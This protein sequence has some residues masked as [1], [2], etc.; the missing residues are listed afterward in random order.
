MTSPDRLPAGALPPVLGAGALQG[1]TFLDVGCGSGLFSLAA[2]RL[3]AARV[4]SFDCDGESVAATQE[5]KRRFAPD[6]G[7]WQ[8]E[9]GDVLDEGYLRSLGEWD[10]VYAW[11]VLHHTGEMWRAL[12]NAMSR[13]RPGGTIF[14]AIYNDQGALS[15]IWRTIKRGYNRSRPTRWAIIALFV[16]AM[17]LHG[18]V[19]DV[20]RA[21]R[22]PLDRYR[23]YAQRSRGMSPRHDWL[24][25]LGGYP[26]EV[27]RPREVVGF[28]EARGFETKTVRVVDGWGCNQ[29]VFRRAR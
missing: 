19:M 10:V 15:R 28:C 5:V 3:G 1:A 21:R 16:P 4:R 2:A 6:A 20:V 9:Q 17:V 27:A 7:A 11:G 8:I 24:D 12:E 14:I 25:W 22:N 26:Y 13:V 18:A 29:F 23:S